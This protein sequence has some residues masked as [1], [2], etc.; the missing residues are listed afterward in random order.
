MYKH[1]GRKVGP[2]QVALEVPPL[3]L[4]ELSLWESSMTKKTPN[5][6]L[7]LYKQLRKKGKKKEKKKYINKS[8]R[9]GWQLD[10]KTLPVQ[11]TRG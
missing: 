6:A 4:A 3:G 8:P 2:A 10:L 11:G 1:K 7:T 5:L 9:M